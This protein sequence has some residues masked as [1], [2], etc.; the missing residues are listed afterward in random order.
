[1]NRGK[2]RGAVIE[3][4]H[5]LL[6]FFF[7]LTG[8]FAQRTN[9]TKVKLITNPEEYFD[10]LTADEIVVTDASFVSDDVMELRYENKENFIEPNVKTN[11]VIAA[12]TT[13]HA[14]L[15]LYS[16]LEHLGER[17]LYYDMDSVIYVIKPGEME[18]ETGVYLGELTDE[19]DGNYITTF[20]SGGPK[21]YA[22]KLN[23]GKT[24]CKI[25]GITLNF[26]TLETVN[27]DV[28]RDMLCVISTTRTSMN[29]SKPTARP[30]LLLLPLLQPMPV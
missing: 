4:F 14:R 11:V 6:L 15:K 8:K 7:C 26:Q 30:T 2:K 18:P 12:F 17:V 20:V 22:Y 10:M 1:M 29:L 19:L 28:M 24:C 25:R 23:N 3:M 9:M 21:N 5:L 16:T 13:A 27:F